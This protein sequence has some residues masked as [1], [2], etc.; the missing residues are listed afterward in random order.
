[1]YQ[2]DINE[3]LLPRPQLGTWLATQACGLTGNGTT[4]GLQASTQST[5]PHQPGLPPQ[6]FNSNDSVLCTMC[7][8][9]PVVLVLDSERCL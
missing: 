1:M 3:L 9:I 6:Y 5:E 8:S 2:R 4:F 7:L